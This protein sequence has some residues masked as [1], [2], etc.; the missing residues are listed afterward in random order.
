MPEIKMLHKS[1]YIDEVE[2]KEV[3][4]GKAKK[5]LIFLFSDLLIV[6]R[7]SKDKYTRR[8]IFPL[9]SVYVFPNGM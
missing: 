8:F 4:K 1:T 7:P 3:D 6:V 5:V 9:G 2:A